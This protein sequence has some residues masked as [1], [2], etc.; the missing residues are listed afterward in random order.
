M[1]GTLQTQIFYSDI[2]TDLTINPISEDIGRLTNENAIRRSIRNLLLTDFYERP[3]KP[4]IGSNLR[5]L[6]FELV[7]PITVELLQKSI[8]D[9]INNYEPRANLIDVI[10]TPY[11]DNN[12]IDVTI[13]FSIINREEPITMQL[14]LDRIR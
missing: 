7:T 8:T 14:S 3:F 10:C 4:D 1:S 13:V 9:V 2:D 11:E 12:A 6:L 5:K